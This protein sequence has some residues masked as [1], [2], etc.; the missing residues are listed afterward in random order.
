MSSEVAALRQQIEKELEGMQRGFSGFAV[1]GKHEV[2]ANK[3]NTLG[4]YQ[5]QLARSIGD[6]AATQ[7]IC[8]AYIRIIG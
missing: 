5:E 8:E 4:I 1:V 3:Y 2:I 6:A 7:L